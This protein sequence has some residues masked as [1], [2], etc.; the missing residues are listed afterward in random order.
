MA[1]V[2]SD[3]APDGKDATQLSAGMS[4]AQVSDVHGGDAHTSANPS[5]ARIPLVVT[6]GALAAGALVFAVIE[7][8][9]WFNKGDTFN[10]MLGCNRVAANRGDPGCADLYDDGQRAKLLTFVGYGA[11]AALAATSVI[12]FYALDN[13]ETADRQVACSIDPPRRGLACALRF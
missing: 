13:G 3:H 1:E 4:D 10:G 6:T 11:A 2:Q 9:T 8:T 7:H 12:L 5:A